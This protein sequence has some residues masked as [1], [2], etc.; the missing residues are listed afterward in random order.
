MEYGPCPVLPPA[1][2]SAPE[3]C[4]HG[5][6][7]GDINGTVAFWETAANYVVGTTEHFFEV[8][9]I[10]PDEGGSINGVDAG[11]WNFSTFKFRAS[12]RVTDTSPEWTPLLGYKYF[13]MGTTSDPN[14]GLPV[15]GYDT[16]MFLAKA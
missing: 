7:Q 12:G 9:T 16:G 13:E 14:L 6:V 11:I 15:T 1:T 4:W 8:F 2:V 10:W 3:T 5:T